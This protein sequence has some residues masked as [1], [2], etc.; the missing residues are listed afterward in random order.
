MSLLLAKTQL[1]TDLATLDQCVLAVAE[2]V[3][4]TIFQIRHAQA[5]LQSLPAEQVLALLNHDPQR[6]G[7]VL[8]A[9]A[10]LAAT[11]NESLENLASD[12]FPDRA[13]AG[14]GRPDISFNSETGT[15]EWIELQPNPLPEPDP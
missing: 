11:L 14:I 9:N 12:G 15:F 7:R 4:R 3:H 5:W 10:T 13:P 2:Q 1:E 8:A 6:T